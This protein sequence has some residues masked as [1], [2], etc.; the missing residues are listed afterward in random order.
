MSLKLNSNSINY[1]V[2]TVLDLT[3]I[4]NPSINDT[5]VVTEEG[6]GG[7]F[8][9]RADGTS[10][11]GTIFDS[12][13][14]GKWHRQYEGSVNVKWF[15]AKGDGVTDDT[16]AIQ[17]AINININTYIPRGVYNCNDISL[18]GKQGI[19]IYGDSQSDFR[20]EGA[21]NDGTVIN[22]TGTNT[23]FDLDNLGLDTEETWKV[24]IEDMTLVKNNRDN[25]GNCIS[26]QT[27]N[28]SFHGQI[29]LSG[30]AIAGFNNGILAGST[31]ISI[32][33]L[34]IDKCNIQSNIWGINAYVNVFSTNK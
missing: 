13:S 7:V 20:I 29:Y 34:H 15:G 16:L 25:I 26:I 31:T 22:Y 33:W 14:T 17:N 24:A 8:I 11:G 19:K 21:Y 28:E 6:R 32:G 3:S 27:T 9:Y 5:V 23:L 30:L 18:K 10:N 2:A 1:N 4:V 12:S